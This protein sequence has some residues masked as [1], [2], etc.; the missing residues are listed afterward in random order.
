MSA[1][2]DHMGGKRRREREVHEESA[3]EPMS[4]GHSGA[5]ALLAHHEHMHKAHVHSVDESGGDMTRPRADINLLR[6]SALCISERQLHQTD[7][8]NR[9]AADFLS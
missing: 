1:S 7:F 5:L 6:P 4:P 3:H 2:P 8:H 9:H